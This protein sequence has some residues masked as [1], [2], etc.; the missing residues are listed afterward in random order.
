[1]SSRIDTKLDSRSRIR[2][3]SLASIIC[4]IESFFGL[5]TAYQLSAAAQA[6]FSNNKLFAFIFHLSNSLDPFKDRTHLVGPGTIQ[7]GN[8]G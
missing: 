6:S 3:K 8:S 5:V 2:R 4:A 1:M 7:S